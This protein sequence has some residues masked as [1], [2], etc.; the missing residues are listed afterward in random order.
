MSIVKNSGLLLFALISLNIH[1]Q[2]LEV[3]KISEG[4]MTSKI[5]FAR[6]FDN[7]T[8]V[9]SGPDSSIHFVN[10]S[11]LEESRTISGLKGKPDAFEFSEDRKWIVST[12]FDNEM[13]CW[14]LKSGALKYEL[15]E[16]APGY[17]CS[18]QIRFTPNN[19]SFAAS[20]NCDFPVWK[21]SKGKARDTLKTIEDECAYVIAYAKDGK[22]VY[23]GGN[24][25]VWTL[26]PKN[27]KRID[28]KNTK[29][30]SVITDIALSPDQKMLAVSGREGLLLLNA[31]LSDKFQLKGHTDW[32][33]D[34][35]FSPDSKF[36]YSC[37]GTLFGTDRTIRIWNT[38]NGEC[39]KTMEGHTD[40][41]NTIDISSDGKFLLTASSDFSMKIWSTI[42]QKLICT[43]VPLKINNTLK[44]SYYSPSEIF[45]GP[46][47]FFEL[48]T[49]KK[50]G[51]EISSEKLS[52][53]DAKEKLVQ[54]FK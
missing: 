45:Y 20:Y 7:K 17:V 21:I 10:L 41:V 35:V 39:I 4:P 30:T 29:A 52:T 24:N 6:F 15:G 5:I 43:I 42:S 2:T 37:S 53:K 8:I 40:D 23:M 25:N 33:N 16:Y 18:K 36:L 9:F 31:D 38:S 14:N 54:L 22:K 46:E 28:L 47:E 51:Q 34:I 13:N 27:K 44:Y 11:T 3:S 49:I 12:S 1:A 19:K 50:D 26:N 32:I 48:V